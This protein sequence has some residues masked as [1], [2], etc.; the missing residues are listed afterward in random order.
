MDYANRLLRPGLISCR[1]W[2]WWLVKRALIWFQVL[3]RLVRLVV[4]KRF[5]FSRLVYLVATIFV[6]R[7]VML[8]TTENWL[9][10]VYVTPDDRQSGVPRRYA[11]CFYG[12]HTSLK[13][14]L[15]SIKCNVFEPITD[16]GDTYDVFV[17]T[18]LDDV[19]GED[20][21]EDRLSANEALSL[22]E[23]IR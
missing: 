12:P 3:S 5:F 17:H 13:H 8:Q 6:I 20:R 1:V 7:I 14:V 21:E 16:Q 18:F 10:D 9:L 2:F 15:P 4:E 23:P 19:P 22:L 11:I